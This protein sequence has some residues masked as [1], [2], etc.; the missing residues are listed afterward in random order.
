MS[1]IIGPIFFILI[2]LIIPASTLGAQISADD[3]ISPIQVEGEEQ[4]NIQEIASPQ[5]VKEV[6]GLDNKAALQAST[7]QDAVNAAVQRLTKLGGGCEE[8]KFPSGFGFVASG[9][10]TYSAMKNAS[11]ALVAQRHAYQIAYMAA[12]KNLAQYL[13]GLSSSA[14][15]SLA[16][17]YRTV[18]SADSPTMSNH[19]HE[20]A[21][22]IQEIVQGMIKGYVVYSVTDTQ[23]GDT[24]DVTVSIVA[25]PKTIGKSS[26]IDTSSIAADTLKAG[27]DGVLSELESGL[28][29]P[30]GGKVITVPASGELA[31]VGFGSAVIPDNPNKAIHKKM[32]INAAKIAQ[33][34]ARC[35]LCGIIL[36]D[37]IKSSESTEGGTQ[38]LSKQF[39]EVQAGDPVT[40]NSNPAQLKKLDEQR[41]HFLNNQ[42][43]KSELS[44]IRN[45]TLPP[46]VN[47]KT[48]IDDERPIVEAVAV[49]LPSASSRAATAREDM[50]SSNI[51][52]SSQ[53]GNSAS[54]SDAMGEAKL[55]KPGQSGKITNDAD[56]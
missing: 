1:K 51:L 42:L 8:I 21:E 27:L 10:G 36:G 47:V 16:E 43:T 29:P 32:M 28:L 26:R 11:A 12:K 48:Y 31:F 17:E 23:D 44:S 53:A 34:R 24:G 6:E 52:P 14:K 37:E 40:E 7:A 9:S 55:P 2:C 19:S 39:E 25:T 54:S 35:A 33:M 50:Q 22:N 4:K 41:E 30:V 18:I 20:Y 56:L 13:H 38:I 15:E 49:Y 46:G 5:E 45:G 3:F